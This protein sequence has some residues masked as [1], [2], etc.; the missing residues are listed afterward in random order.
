[1][2]A[3]V[4]DQ[5]GVCSSRAAMVTVVRRTPSI[6]PR[7]SCVSG[8]TLPS[9]QSWVCNSQRQSLASSA[10]RVVIKPFVTPASIHYNFGRSAVIIQ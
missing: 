3:A 10:R 5:A 4:A 7:N 9:I 8:M 2:T 6:C 1:V